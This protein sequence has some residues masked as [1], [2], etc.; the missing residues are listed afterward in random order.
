MGWAVGYDR[1]WDR[2]IGY[3]VPAVC[4][5]PGCTKKI[6]RGLSYVCGSEPFGGEHGCGLYFCGD[7][8]ECREPRGSDT[9]VQNC[10]R[11]MTYKMPYKPKPDR[12]EW[13]EHKLSDPSW[14]EWRDGH[15]SIV[16]ELRAEIAA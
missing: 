5:H 7:H 15:P 3:G 11:C 2:D 4:D 9:A 16:A 1:N 13:V 6:H 12:R 14:Q 10:R 8:L